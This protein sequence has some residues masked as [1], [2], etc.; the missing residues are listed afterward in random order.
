M[1]LLVVEG[2]EGF[3]VTTGAAPQ[4]AGALARQ[5]TV[6]NEAAMDIETGRLSGYSL[7]FG[8]AT[9]L[10]KT[11]ALTVDD[12]LII[13]FAVKV[14][15]LDNPTLV[16]LYD[17][18]ATGVQL[19][20]TPTGALSIYRGGALLG[21]SSPVITIVDT[22]YYVELKVK[23][24]NATGT[25][26]VRVGGANILS[27]SG[28]D[29]RAG[30][31]DYHDLVSFGMAF[32]L[33]TV[34]FDD[35]YICDSS[36]AVNNTFLGNSRVVSILP[37]GDDTAGWNT[38][39]GGSSHYLDVDE[40]PADDDTTYLEDNASGHKD[41]FDYAAM[42]GS[43]GNIRGLAIKTI[44]RETDASS[45]SIIMPIK[46]NVTETDDSSQAIGTTSYVTKVRVSELDPDTSA[47]WVEAGV[48]A[49]KFGIKTG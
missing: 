11:G 13:G 18:V 49:A 12:T 44:C 6:T 45:F 21:T 19:I 28:V 9:C 29:T 36:G 10:M 47:P 2:F 1:A 34:T 39:S 4:P 7:E 26:E 43:L 41:L 48:N 42:P 25:Y 35:I 3:G 14:S 17:G 22:W 23:C 46:S 37:D 24:N 8:N 15:A 31:H 40:N 20:M 16:A 38:A 27:D 30:A 32:G 5:Y 33:G